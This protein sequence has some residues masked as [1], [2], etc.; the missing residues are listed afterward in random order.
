MKVFSVKLFILM[1]FQISMKDDSN[2]EP[3]L[4]MSDYTPMRT[5]SCSGVGVDFLEGFVFHCE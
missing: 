2:E 3:K 4:K 5:N 1:F